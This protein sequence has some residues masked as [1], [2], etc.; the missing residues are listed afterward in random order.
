MKITV[1]ECVKTAD[2]TKNS[3]SSACDTMDS[4]LTTTPYD[5]FSENASSAFLC[6]NDKENVRTF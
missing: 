6:Q 3:S 2:E 5:G 4:K 1:S